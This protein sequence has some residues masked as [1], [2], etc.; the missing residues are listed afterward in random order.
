MPF[1]DSDLIIAFGSSKSTTIL[2]RVLLFLVIIMITFNAYF[3]VTKWMSKETVEKIATIENVTKKQLVEAIKASKKEHDSSKQKNAV[4]TPSIVKDNTLEITEKIDSKVT[5]YAQLY[6]GLYKKYLHIG[7][8]L[9]NTSYLAQKEI[10]DKMGVDN[11]MFDV[12]LSLAKQLVLLQIDM[13]ESMIRSYVSHR[14]M[15]LDFYEQI[16][17]RNITDFGKMYSMFNYFKK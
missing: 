2:A 1:Y 9:C 7:S 3:C 10:F 15:M 16:M 17:N 4:S 12:Y 13:N 11:T 6:S 8:N 14:L 5:S